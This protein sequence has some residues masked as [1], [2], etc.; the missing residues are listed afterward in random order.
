MVEYQEWMEIGLNKCGS[1]ERTF[2]VLAQLWTNNR[3]MLQEMSRTE[4]RDCLD[5]P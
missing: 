3:Q 4:A 2:G 5:C 1:D